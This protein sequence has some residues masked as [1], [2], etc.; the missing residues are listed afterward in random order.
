MPFKVWLETDDGWEWK[1]SDQALSFWGEVK[2]EVFDGDGEWIEVVPDEIH[3]YN[4]SVTLGRCTNGPVRV[5]GFC[6]PLSLVASGPWELSIQKIVGEA[7]LGGEVASRT[8]A[9]TASLRMEYVDPSLTPFLASEGIL[10]RL[11]SAQ[12]MFYGEGRAAE[13]DGVLVV[14]FDAEGVKTGRL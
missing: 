10:C 2:T 4:G 3:P 6:Y 5:K 13:A 14:T 7:M 9:V 8:G 1:V 12:A 11:V